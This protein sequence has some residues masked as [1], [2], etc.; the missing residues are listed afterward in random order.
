MSAQPHHDRYV[1]QVVLPSGR[2]IDV[3]YFEDRNAAARS[4]RPERRTAEHDLHVCPKCAS[5]LV[6]PV[7]WEEASEI[8][9]HVHLR[10]P[11]CE[12]LGEGVFEQEVVERFDVELDRGTESVVSDLHHLSRANMEEDV[13][14]FALALRADHILPCD[15]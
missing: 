10:C 8:S 4:R 5:E 12:W 11:N 14:R 3:V 7:E 9:W 1:R 15:F 6:Y 2:T 13:E